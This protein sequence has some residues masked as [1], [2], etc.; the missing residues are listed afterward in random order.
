MTIHIA[1][2]SAERV[3]LVLCDVSMTDTSIDCWES[4]LVIFLAGPHEMN[5]VGRQRAIE[6]LEEAPNT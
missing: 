4:R 6:A 2:Y 3:T 1:I 5:T